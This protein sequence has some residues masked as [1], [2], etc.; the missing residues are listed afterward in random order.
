MKKFETNIFI[1]LLASLAIHSV[2]IFFINRT[3]DRAF[4]QEEQ[5]RV[6]M[7]DMA[8]LSRPEKTIKKARV[9]P[10]NQPVED[11]SDQK[12]AAP[13]QK[14]MTTETKQ[15]PP[16]PEIATIVAKAVS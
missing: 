6:V 2:L 4:I 1:F 11:V 16:T 14:P 7:L 12:L 3:K 9:Q 10:L 8:S 5:Y 15:H 13:K